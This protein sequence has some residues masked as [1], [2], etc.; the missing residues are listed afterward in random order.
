MLR[1]ALAGVRGFLMRLG[2]ATVVAN[3]CTIWQTRSL[4]PVRR[5]WAAS[6]GLA[7]HAAHA[8]A[9][10]IAHGIDCRCFYTENFYVSQPVEGHFTYNGPAEFREE[11]AD[12]L[13]SLGDATGEK[14]VSVLEAESRR[15][16][17]LVQLAVARKRRIGAE[18]SR[19]HGDLWRLHERWLHPDFLRLTE[20]ARVAEATGRSLDKFATP[21]AIAEGVYALQVFSQEF[22]ALLC[23]ELDHF[24]ASGLPAGRPNSMNNAGVLLDEL[25]FSP[26]FLEPLLREY[27]RPLSSALPA[28]ASLGGAHLDHHKSFVVRYKMGEDEEL[29]AHY[30]N[31]EVTLNVNL[32]REFLGGE[33]VFYGPKEDRSA[34][35]SAYHE[36]SRR[37]VGHGVLHIGRQVHAALPIAHGERLNFVMWLRSSTQRSITGCPMCD[38]TDRLLTRNIM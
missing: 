22:C 15:R 16:R 12:L 30:D 3:L 24:S 37:G 23:D 26:D 38:Q 13:S 34:S 36:W 14:L 20:A 4:D 1:A 25:G 21:P 27:L 19:K 17:D 2:R 33:L 5:A 10:E 29:A 28:L 8:H 18:Y 9:E 32:G 6:R 11:N 35:V 31:S 7:Q